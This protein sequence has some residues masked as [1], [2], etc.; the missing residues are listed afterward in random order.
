MKERRTTSYLKLAFFSTGIIVAFSLLFVLL[1]NSYEIGVKT[2]KKP[3]IQL[4]NYLNSHIIRVHVDKSAEWLQKRLKYRDYIRFV[5]TF[6]NIEIAEEA[7]QHTID[8]NHE[9]IESWVRD[10]TI[11]K[12]MRKSF[13]KH[14]DHPIGFGIHRRQIT[15]PIELYDIK[16]VIQKVNSHSYKI[17]TAY[18]IPQKR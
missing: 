1:F 15:T 16:V 6:Y 3:V 12:N 8:D 9:R 7:I 4:G 2:T 11:T 10:Q 13:R 18:P 14:F 5:S 17:I